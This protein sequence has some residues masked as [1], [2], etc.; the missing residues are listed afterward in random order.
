M[1]ILNTEEILTRLPEAM[2]RRKKSVVQVSMESGLP[3]S[4]ISRLAGNVSTRQIRSSIKTGTAIK[5][6]KWLNAPDE[7]IDA[8]KTD[9]HKG[10]I[11]QTIHGDP[12][13][14]RNAKSFLVNLIDS[15]Y[16]TYG[17]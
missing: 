4:T 8:R 3:N 1:R 2:R 14:D 6:S 11:F 5:I 9:D 12:R 13:L 17:K 16:T 7:S 15:G 10:A